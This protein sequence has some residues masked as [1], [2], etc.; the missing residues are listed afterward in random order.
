MYSISICFGPTGTVWNFLFKEEE[1]A[2]GVAENIETA[3]GAPAARIGILDDFGQLFQ[4][5]VDQIHGFLLECLDE[6]QAG[7]IE[8]GL[9]NARVQAKAQERAMADE[10]ISRSLRRQAAGPAVMTPFG[11]TPRMNG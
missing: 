11:G 3:L 5:R 1:R 7:Q 8:R 4:G 6:S 2:R 10:V 9:H